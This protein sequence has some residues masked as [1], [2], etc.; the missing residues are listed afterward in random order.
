MEKWIIDRIFS[1]VD[2]QAKKVEDLSK[3]VHENASTLGFA[4]KILISIILFMILFGLSSVM[5]TD[6]KQKIAPKKQTEQ[7]QKG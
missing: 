4:M 6:I 5:D 7:N 3:I 1:E 2:S